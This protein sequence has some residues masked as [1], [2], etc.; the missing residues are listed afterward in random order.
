MAVTLVV[1][2]GLM[3]VWAPWT[4]PVLRPPRPEVSAGPAERLELGRSSLSVPVR[5]DLEALLAEVEEHVPVA[6]GDL[7]EPVGLAE[8]GRAVTAIELAREPFDAVFRGPSARLSSMVSYRVR[9]TYDLPLLPDINFGCATGPADVWPR[10]EVALLAPV[11]LTD[12]WRLDTKT[13]VLDIRP[14]TEGARDRCRVTAVDV[15]I[16]ERVVGAAREFL[17][18]HTGVI[19]SIVAGADVRS[20]FE[21]WWGV[22][23]EPVRIGDELWLEIRPEAISKGRIEGRGRV[24]EVQA[25]LGARPRV[26]LGARPE[27]S[28]KPLPSLGDGALA[29]PLEVL[30]E[31]VGE[32]GEATRLLSEVLGGVDFQ[33]GERRVE[34][35]SVDLTGI[36]AGRVALEARIGGS[37][38]GSL[39]LVGTPRYDP[40]TGL[41]SVPD[42]AFSVST[43]SLLLGGASWILESGLESFLRERARWPV[44]PALEWAGQRLH[45]G[46]NRSL[47]DG[48][49]LEGAVHD[50]RVVGIRATPT[51][52]LVGAAAT[53]DATLHVSAT[54]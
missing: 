12:D 21:S 4:A 9:G 10:L 30:V 39:F 28:T 37:V 8:G 49:R 32:Y 45:E 1:L 7:S 40:A 16:T 33:I 5:I 17:E 3:L 47:A 54:G 43:S 24:V 34:L 31:A 35:R 19:D 6:W 44:E 22:L 38:E 42:L 29:G 23:R 41:A 51:A 48:V 25:S 36:G 11:D 18:E 46:L 15:D 14:A 53:A 27:P 20:R 2:S 13:Q 26:V 50:I 52:L